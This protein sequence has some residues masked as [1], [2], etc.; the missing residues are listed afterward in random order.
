MTSLIAVQRVGHRHILTPDGYYGA[1]LT[2]CNESGEPRTP[3][4]DIDLEDA[5]GSTFRPLDATVHPELTYQPRRLEPN[6][7]E[8][9]D[10]S[11]ADETFNGAALVFSVPFDAVQRRPRASGRSRSSGR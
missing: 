7:C 2:V 3:T 10:G 6:G 11:P 5:F 8:P 9:A 1:F 4:G